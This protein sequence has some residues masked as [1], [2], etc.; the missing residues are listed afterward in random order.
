MFA[1]VAFELVPESDTNAGPGLTALGLMAGA[2]V[3]V[4][5]DRRLSRSRRA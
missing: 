5:A 2:L 3:Y 1:A 4:A